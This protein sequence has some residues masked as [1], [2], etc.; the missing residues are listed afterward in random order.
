ML[1]ANWIKVVFVAHIEPLAQP[2]ANHTH[3]NMINAT[4]VAAAELLLQDADFPKD[5]VNM[6][7]PDDYI[8]IDK[9]F[10]EYIVNSSAH[11]NRLIVRVCWKV[12]DDKYI[13]MSFVCDTGAPTALY[14]SQKAYKLLTDCKRVLEDDAGN[15]Y[16]SVH[17][18]GSAAVEPT[19]PGHAP[20]NIIG[21][22]LLMR[23]KLNLSS[24]NFVF[25][26]IQGYF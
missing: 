9:P 24:S 3:N 19:P 25:E 10:V 16:A 5:Y 8:V 6:Q 26:N 14:L 20:A 13:P 2:N 11:H 23:L 18:T 17:G 22:K 12:N 15:V 7:H 21:L 4:E 1:H